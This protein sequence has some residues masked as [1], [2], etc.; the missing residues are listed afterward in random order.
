MFT[1]YQ[2][3]KKRTY[4]RISGFFG[5][6]WG[7]GTL[8][9]KYMCRKKTHQISPSSG[10][11]W[12]LGWQQLVFRLYKKKHVV[13]FLLSCCSFSPLECAHPENRDFCSCCFSC[14]CV[15]RAWTRVPERLIEWVYEFTELLHLLGP[16]S[17]L[18]HRFVYFYFNCITAALWYILQSGR[19]CSLCYSYLNFSRLFFCYDAPKISFWGFK[20]NFTSNID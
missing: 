9:Y 11:Y 6:K 5:E 10:Y 12:V 8:F 7:G 20:W 2:T 15:P 4:S 18:C 19:T 14:R 16:Q 1:T 17:R 3:G 13:N